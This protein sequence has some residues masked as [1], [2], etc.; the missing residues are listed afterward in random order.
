M[1]GEPGTMRGASRG[2]G[3]GGSH[4][5]W[6]LPAG[7]ALAVLLFAIQWYAYDVTRGTAS[8]YI[9]YLGWSCLMWALAPAVLWFVRRHPLESPRWR[10]SIALHLIVSIALSV[11]Q[12]L[13]EAS[14]AWLRHTHGLAFQASLAHYFRQHVQLYLL[15]Y[16]ALVAVAHFYRIHD[17][18]RERQLRAARL[19]A[20]L[21]AARL[22][23]LRSQLQPHFLFNTLH[24]AVALVHENPDAVEDIL[25]RLST[26]LRA[27]LTELHVQEVPLQ[28]ELEFLECYIGIQQRRF[29]ERLRVDVHFAP[30]V[31]DCA[32]PSLV[33][34]P[35]VENAIRHGI[36]THKESDVVTVNA[37]QEGG[38]LVLEIINRSS[39]LHEAPEQLMAR[40]VGL[41]NTRARLRQLHGHRQTMQL[42][43]LQP[44]GVCVR[45]TLPVRHCTFP[46]DSVHEE[47][48]CEF[49]R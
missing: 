35:L 30:S 18:A 38:Q 4:E 26:L 17:R 31:L 42:L 32:V 33:L 46:R 41:A 40:G 8:P 36:G 47:P 49:A 39:E 21:S 45:L 14:I 1:F 19:E 10:D 22:Q 44:R 11:F 3:G 9:D 7:W 24:A 13:I 25:V 27:S 48:N 20:Q 43:N 29:G 16:W 12:V 34:Q 15:T 6:L 37:S 5:R 2:D 28:K 23:A